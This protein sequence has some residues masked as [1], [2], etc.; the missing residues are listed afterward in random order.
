[1]K[2]LTNKDMIEIL[3]KMQAKH[4]DIDWGFEVGQT[5]DKIYIMWGY[6]EGEYWVI[7]K[8][9]G[10]VKDEHNELRNRELE[11]TNNIEETLRS[12]I[13]YMVSRY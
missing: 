8:H 4:I 11:N 7:D 13:Y 3:K 1:M 12:I 6:L 5:D 9:S 10:L 2:K